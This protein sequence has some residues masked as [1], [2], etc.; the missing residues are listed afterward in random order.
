MSAPYLSALNEA[1]KCIAS[2]IEALP[3]DTHYIVMADHGGH[4][5]THGTQ[6]EEDM[7]IPVLTLGPGIKMGEK[8]E[9]GVS[10]IDIA[11]SILQILGVSAPKEWV[12]KP[13]TQS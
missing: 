12:G 11:P 3:D 6:L 5:R 9:D 2:V 10:I 1:D 13:L 7:Y 4:G 8:L